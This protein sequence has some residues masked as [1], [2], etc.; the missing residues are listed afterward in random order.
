MVQKTVAMYE[1][2]W[3][4][5]ALES[6]LRFLLL[7]GIGGLFVVGGRRYRGGGRGRGRGNRGGRRRRRRRRR[8]FRY[9][10]VREWYRFR[11]YVRLEDSLE[12]FLF[13]LVR[14]GVVP[15]GA[16]GAV[17]RPLTTR[18]PAP[19]PARSHVIPLSNVLL[20]YVSVLNGEMR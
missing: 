6:F 18:A 1:H 16:H 19:A 14:V 13:K 15:R 9:H 3:A 4:L 11:G 7:I 20:M 8:R 2:S 12:Y 10:C 5:G 17:G